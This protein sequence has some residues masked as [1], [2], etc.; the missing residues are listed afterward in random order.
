[1]YLGI[2][3]ITHRIT[4]GLTTWIG[5]K[6]DHDCLPERA[7]PLLPLLPLGAEQQN[8]YD[9]AAQMHR[10]LLYNALDESIGCRLEG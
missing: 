10:L 2:N 8:L 1:M 4:C 6:E 3:S 9:M 7:L 5:W